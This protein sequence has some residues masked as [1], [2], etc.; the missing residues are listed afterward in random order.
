M[1]VQGEQVG[2]ANETATDN[3]KRETLT[4]IPPTPTEN[5]RLDTG[6]SLL[7]RDAQKGNGNAEG[8]TKKKKGLGRFKSGHKKM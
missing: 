7:T 5:Q 4:V 6:K 2:E 3:Q 8:G 1:V